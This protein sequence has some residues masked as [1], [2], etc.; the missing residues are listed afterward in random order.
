MARSV[1]V[2]LDGIPFVVPA[3]NIAQLQDVAE[4]IS[5]T[6]PAITGFGILKIAMRRAT[7][8]PD[9]DTLAPG[10][11]EIGEAVQAILKMSG[12]QKPENP[13][14]AVVGGTETSR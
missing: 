7:P 8:A 2:Q 14:L 13:T 9:W 6:A 3:L 11:D 12:L 10:L 1:T 5:G 4:A